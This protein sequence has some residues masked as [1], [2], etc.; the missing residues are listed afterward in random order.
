MQIRARRLRIVNTAGARSF[1][2]V[3]LFVLLS[4][5]CCL[6][7]KREASGS[8]ATTTPQSI[9]ITARAPDAFY[10]PPSQLPQQ[11]G[12]LIRSEPLKNVTLPAGMRGW[13]I[14]Y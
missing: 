11:P 12:L 3:I 10:D 1:G 7:I 9:R 14:L 5:G 8:P 6:H 13:R 2:L 4:S